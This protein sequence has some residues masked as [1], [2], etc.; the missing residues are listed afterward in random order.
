MRSEPD[1]WSGEGEYSPTTKCRI[2]VN[3][4]GGYTSTVVT[5]RDY[6]FTVDLPP[7]PAAGTQPRFRV[8]SSTG[9]VGAGA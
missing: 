8:A 3:G 2:Y 7:A 5:D 9:G 6:E 1:R 4:H